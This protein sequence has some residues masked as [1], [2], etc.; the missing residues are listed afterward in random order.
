[1]I[2]MLMFAEKSFRALN[3]DDLK[4]GSSLAIKVLSFVVT[5]FLSI[6][7]LPMLILN[8]QGFLC[9]EDKDDYYV[10]DEIKCKSVLNEVLTI[11]STITMVLFIM[12][13]FI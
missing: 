1:M 9:N 10:I 12:F 8:I 4:D 5:L 13:C 6:F 7:F 3:R 11:I 2:G